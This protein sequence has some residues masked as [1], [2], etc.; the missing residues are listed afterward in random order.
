MLP[1]HLNFILPSAARP[2]TVADIILEEQ[3]GKS[4][5]VPRPPPR[6]QGS[7]PQECPSCVRLPTAP[8]P[9]VPPDGHWVPP[10]LW[11]GCPGPCR[12]CPLPTSPGEE[13]LGDRGT[14]HGSSPSRTWLTF[15]SRRQSWF[16]S[17]SGPAGKP[18][19]GPEAKVTG[20]SLDPKPAGPES[21][22]PPPQAEQAPGL[23][24]PKEGKRPEP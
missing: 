24:V 11:L 4:L 5:T 7:K 8:A 13:A 3:D 16:G 21:P 14:P 6:P 22:E 12:A 19:P 2:A 1:A 9:A 15:A 17:S 10:W 18:P 23:T 20:P